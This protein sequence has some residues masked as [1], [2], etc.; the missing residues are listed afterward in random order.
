M[1]KVT[2]SMRKIVISI[3]R[4]VQGKLVVEKDDQFLLYVTGEG[5]TGKSWVIETVRLGMKLLE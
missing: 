2:V 5:D 3:R 1:R 4:N